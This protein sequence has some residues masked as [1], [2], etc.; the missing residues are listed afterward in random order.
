MFSLV[1]RVKLN[2]TGP[3]WLALIPA[4]ASYLLTMP[5]ESLLRRRCWLLT[6]V[7]VAAFYIGL[8]QYL[9]TGIPGIGY[10]EVN[11]T[12]PVGWSEFGRE[13][14]RRKGALEKATGGAA[15]IVGMDKYFIASEAAFYQKN[16]AVAV[17]ET[18]G[19]HLFG[20]NSL[21]YQLWS[22]AAEQRGA[23]LLL[24]AFDRMDLDRPDIPKLSTSCGPVE[25]LWLERGGKK[26]CPYYVQVISN[27]LGR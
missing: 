23:T 20:G 7:L 13:L 26:I 24:V 8:L 25:E 27:Y 14:D 21:M 12:V 10:R 15:R 4:M 22:P 6:I 16:Q 9:S 18:T 11:K 19:A 17:R 3:I 2:W 5:K 1:H